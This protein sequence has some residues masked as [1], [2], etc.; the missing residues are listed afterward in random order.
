MKIL[1]KLNYTDGLKGYMVDDGDVSY[2]ILEASLHV[3]E[4]TDALLE[5]GYKLVSLPYDYRYMGQSINSLPERTYEPSSME[6]Q[7][8]FDLN[9]ADTYSYE[10]LR[11]K[12]SVEDVVYV[13]T[14]DTHYKINTRTEFLN[15]LYTINIVGDVYKGIP[16]NYFV[17]KDALFT[18]KEYTSGEYSTEISIINGRRK[19][20]Y[21]EYLKSKEFL[22]LPENSTAQD[23]METYYSWGIDGLNM[24]FI[25]RDKKSTAISLNMH[26][27]TKQ[28][29][30]EYSRLTYAAVDRDSRVY[31]P[32]G[33]RKGTSNW[34]VGLPNGKE[35]RAFLRKVSMLK[36]DEIDIVP[37]RCKDDLEYI[38]FDSISGS[39]KVTFSTIYLD[40]MII[41]NFVIKSLDE[42]EMPISESMLNDADRLQDIFKLNALANK[43]VEKC[44]IKADVSTYKALLECGLDVRCALTYIR[45]RMME[46]SEAD[47]AIELPTDADIE[48]YV[49]DALDD[50]PA[51]DA[52]ENYVN[53]TVALDGIMN[54]RLNDASHNTFFYYKYLYVAHFCNMRMSI[55][56]LYNIVEHMED[57]IEVRSG[58]K[59]L[60]ISN[61]VAT[62]YMPCDDID[63]EYRGY[64]ADIANYKLQMIDKS[65]GFN[66]VTVIAR[67]YGCNNARRHVAFA[68][69]AV[70]IYDSGVKVAL[71]HLEEMYE[72]QMARV[73]LDE[74]AINES[75]KYKKMWSR[76]Q[77]FRVAH[78]GTVEYPM[79]LGG[80]IVHVPETISRICIST[81]KYRIETTAYYCSRM[82]EDGFFTHYCVN[83]DI[84]PEAVIPKGGAELPVISL[85]ALWYNWNESGLGQLYQIIKDEVDV[86]VYPWTYAWESSKYLARSSS[87]LTLPK[88]ISIYEKLLS[89]NAVNYPHEEYMMYPGLEEVY[90]VSDYGDGVIHMAYVYKVSK[91]DYP[92]HGK[93]ERITKSKSGLSQFTGF[94]IEDMLKVDVSKIAMPEGDKLITVAGD[95]ISTVE[96]TD[97]SP[98]DI[99]RLH[100]ENSG[101][102]IINPYGRLYI[103]RDSSK[104][105]W[106]IVI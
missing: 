96:Q 79:E 105:L 14:P 78:K 94:T 91:K 31:V 102:P 92:M 32:K 98:N 47:E 72:T 12:L 64:F 7:D 15:Y 1:E 83:A 100:D 103:F 58:Y 90:K 81:V 53:G 10:E 62:L 19:M 49:N 55:E 21:T 73:G 70:N 38:Q 57:H 20:T 74:A 66:Q 82:Y 36:D 39:C 16:L 56:D 68:C 2:P 80:E 85:R 24:D 106:R 42:S 35:D 34:Y 50:T 67:E 5:S 41:P 23:Y 54:G 9:S 51:Q 104:R 71:K 97:I 22:K 8:M 48:A 11:S 63:G 25:S 43:V 101:Y 75:R 40:D 52:L 87:D 89:E 27:Y 93:V 88:L 45:D 13:D 18:L 86:D 28:D 61:D 65:C 95:S 59:Y 17:N 3:M 6:M 30:V 29:E 77:Y 26:D 4:I 84:T 60:K 44:T 33:E 37:V 46:G 76:K 69:E 99:A